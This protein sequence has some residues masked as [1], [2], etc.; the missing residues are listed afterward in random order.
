[1]ALDHWIK[2]RGMSASIYNSD[3]AP[4]SR[5][6]EFNKAYPHIYRLF[7]FPTSQ[8]FIYSEGVFPYDVW[9]S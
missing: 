2:K 5:L 6:E 4:L 8:K 1:M 3:R 7:P 9:S